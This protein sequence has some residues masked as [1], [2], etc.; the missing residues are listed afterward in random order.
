[1]NLNLQ[2]RQ[3]RVVGVGDLAHFFDGGAH[4]VLAE[5][6]RAGDKR[7]GTGARAFGDSL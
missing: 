5:Q 6:G 1:V 2:I 3:R 4:I 7:V